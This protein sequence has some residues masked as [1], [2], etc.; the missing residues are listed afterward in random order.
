MAK[1]IDNLTTELENKNAEI[2]IL[3]GELKYLRSVNELRD[4][5]DDFRNLL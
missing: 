3:N 1:R 4:K 5:D 2:S